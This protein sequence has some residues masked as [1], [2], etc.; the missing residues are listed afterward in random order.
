MKMLWSYNIKCYEEEELIV[1]C[2][3]AIQDIDSK[4]KKIE[5]MWTN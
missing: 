4:N 5:E 3:G 2:G 1:D